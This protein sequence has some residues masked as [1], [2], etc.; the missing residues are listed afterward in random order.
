MVEPSVPG[1]SGPE[2][3]IAAA[4]LEKYKLPGNCEIPTELIQ[5]EGETLLS[6]IHKLINSVWNKEELP[7]IT[8][9]VTKLTVIIIVL[10]RLS[11]Y[12]D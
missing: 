3:K 12:I 8:K 10:S 4:K 5:A 1:S 6:V 11:T 2:C 7:D 9:R